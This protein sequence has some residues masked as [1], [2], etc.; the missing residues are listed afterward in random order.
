VVLTRDLEQG[1]KRRGVALHT[2]SYLLGDVLVD[3]Q[4]RNILALSGELVESGFDG[5]VFGFR[6]HDQEVLLAVGGLGDVLYIQIR[7]MRKGKR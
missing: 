3:E 5:C 1:R 6:V 7:L 2:M 4:N